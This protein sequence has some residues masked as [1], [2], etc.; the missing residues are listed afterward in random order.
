[1]LKRQRDS[2]TNK[3]ENSYSNEGLDKKSMLRDRSFGE[4]T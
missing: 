2:K 3:T 1:M 4:K